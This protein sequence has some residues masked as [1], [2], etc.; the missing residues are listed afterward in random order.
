RDGRGLAFLNAASVR[1]DRVARRGG[2]EPARGGVARQFALPPAA[3][4]ALVLGQYRGASRASPFKRHSLLSASGGL[5]EPSRARRGRPAQSVGELRLCP[6]GA[7]GRGQGT[8][9]FIL[10]GSPIASGGS[11]ARHFVAEVLAHRLG[12]QREA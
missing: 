2:L 3:G 11:L 12:A 1:G 9:R 6:I 5:A 8:D 10:R 7:V 4:T